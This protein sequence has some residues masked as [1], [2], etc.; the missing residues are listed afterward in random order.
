VRIQPQ[1]PVSFVVVSDAAEKPPAMTMKA[2]SPSSELE[3]QCR[4]P[5]I[6]MP[7]DG[8]APEFLTPQGAA[9]PL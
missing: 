7:V 8:F 3:I 9:R 2:S 1:S 6:Q 5:T 4:E